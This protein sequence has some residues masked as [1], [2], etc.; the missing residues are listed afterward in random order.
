MSGYATTRLIFM[1]NPFD[2]PNL[3]EEIRQQRLAEVKAAMPWLDTVFK[4]TDITKRRIGD[5]QIFYLHSG[6]TPQ[7]FPIASDL[8]YG[9]TGGKTGM[10][11]DM[12]CVDVTGSVPPSRVGRDTWNL[13]ISVANVTEIIEEEDT[14]FQELLYLYVSAYEVFDTEADTIAGRKTLK[15]FRGV[16][17]GDVNYK[18]C[19]VAADT[20]RAYITLP[21]F[22]AWL[23][24][25]HQSFKHSQIPKY[26]RESG[27]EMKKRNWGNYWQSPVDFGPIAEM[28]RD[29]TG[30]A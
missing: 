21:I 7:P 14:Q 26:L 11:W 13:L 23:K 6:R 18:T 15:E 16:M 24:S 27:W 9:M 19:G 29:M 10:K 3:P 5:S 25:L 8:L 17:S 20:R 30:V 22:E 1:P 4:L 28:K 2:L 12:W